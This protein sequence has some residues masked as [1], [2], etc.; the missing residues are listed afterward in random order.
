M[1]DEKK[2]RERLIKTS[3]LAGQENRESAPSH[4]LRINFHL[5]F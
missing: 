1:K 2:F 3:I 5:I 4:E